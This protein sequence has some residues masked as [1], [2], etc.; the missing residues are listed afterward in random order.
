[1]M[2]SVLAGEAC[3]AAHGCCSTSNTCRPLPAC[4]LRQRAPSIRS[5]TA[6]AL[7]SLSALLGHAITGPS[8]SESVAQ[9][10]EL[11][12]RLLRQL[13]QQAAGEEDGSSDVVG[14]SK[15]AIQGLLLAAPARQGPKKQLPSACQADRLASSSLLANT[16]PTE[17]D[18]LP[19]RS[20][21]WAVLCELL[22]ASPEEQQPLAQELLVGAAGSHPQHALRLD[23]LVAAAA[24]EPALPAAA[25]SSSGAL[26]AKLAG[27]LLGRCVQAAAAGSPAWASLV[28]ALLGRLWRQ[29]QSQV[30]VALL[31]QLSGHFGPPRSRELLAA[32][33]AR[34]AEVQAE[35]QRQRRQQ[36]QQQEGQQEGQQQ[37]EGREQQHKEEG[38]EQQ[39]QQQQQQ[40][41]HQQQEEGR[42]LYDALAPLLV[43]KVLPLA[44]FDD[45]QQPWLYPAPPQQRQ[46]QGAPAAGEPVATQLAQMMQDV[47]QGRPVRQLAA[48][49]YGRLSPAAT[50]GSACSGAAQAVRQGAAAAF[51]AWLFSLVAAGSLQGPQ[52]WRALCSD[53]ANLQE[54]LGALLEV[55]QLQG[56]G[57]GV[58]A[59]E[60]ELRRC[61]MACIDCLALL[62]T[63]QLGQQ[64]QQ[65]QQ[66]Q[67]PG[68]LEL[69]LQLAGCGGD[70]SAGGP[71]A[72]LGSRWQGR[73]GAQ[74][75]ICIL[76]A[77]IS[78][79][80]RLPEQCGSLF[81]ER[82][83]QPLLAV[84]QR[85]AEP[86]QP[87][88]AAAAAL[89][90]LF[91]AVHS[92]KAPWA[93]LAGPLAQLAL[94]RLAA[95]PAAAA[96]G[97]P[98]PAAPGAAPD[99]VAA[100]KLLAAL[101]AGAEDV[102]QEAA[103][104]VAGARELLAR[105]E[106]RARALPGCEL[107]VVAEALLRCVA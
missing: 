53:Q 82:V 5:A 55:V 31:S 66:Q 58:A 93:P 84:L 29:P 99:A 64:Q 22:A 89:Q 37:E 17:A 95:S 41:E 57:A 20:W 1:M 94:Q 74:A 43:V 73:L 98:E 100:C 23:L 72:L 11:A 62:C 70:S 14:A 47:R 75:R 83:V 88:A 33:Q 59:D 13:V 35:Q 97:G 38:R 80:H 26:D 4:R 91:V 2:P 63:L 79:T 103:G 104:Q 92:V 61:Q 106:R 102:L 49:L 52:L 45:L 34:L 28:A 50:L 68:P 81:V 65:Q 18:D 105:V 107:H 24:G 78:A 8:A 56:G 101:L 42:E 15:S 96:A 21:T 51:R 9:S 39:Q 32:V 30:L 6:R 85:G 16:V 90:L 27:G 77:L 76:N 46:Q 10:E 3:A 12:G 67:Q 19:A 36:Q 60:Q 25:G 86:L 87:P 44:A 69:L 71:L 7:D 54:L 48:E 40:E